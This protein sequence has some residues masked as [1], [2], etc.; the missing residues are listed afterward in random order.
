MRIFSVDQLT[1]AFRGAGEILLELVEL[2]DRTTL[3]RYCLSFT[4]TAIL[5]ERQFRNKPNRALMPRR[6][7]NDFTHS[8]TA[9]FYKAVPAF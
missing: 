2:T 8:R 4:F 1:A 3:H 7:K 9:N 5:P 6:K